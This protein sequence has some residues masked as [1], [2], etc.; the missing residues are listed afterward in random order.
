MGDHN[1]SDT[2][3]EKLRDLLD[4]EKYERRGA[5][6]WTKYNNEPGSR[7]F[8][9]KIL[10]RFKEIQTDY[11]QDI[12]DIGCG[13]GLW[14]HLLRESGYKVTGID[15]N[16]LAIE[17]AM[18]KGLDNMH[19]SFFTDYKGEHDVCI[20]F[21]VFEH[22]EEPKQAVKKLAEIAR[23]KVYILNPLWDVKYHHDFYDNPK[24]TA[25]FSDYWELTHEETLTGYSN[26][27]NTSFEKSF[28]QFTKK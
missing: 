2:H 4:M 18:K 24:I 1:M 15:A 14:T 3:S 19:H 17:L 13:D 26:T 20:L 8:T 27:I 25:I 21:D 9:D 6:H 22:F 5:Y 10:D 7:A 12:L 11:E 16:K 23:H 28:L